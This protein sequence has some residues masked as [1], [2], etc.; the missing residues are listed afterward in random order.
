V[1][2][3][4]FTLL[5][6]IP[7]FGFNQD[8]DNTFGGDSLDMGYSLQQTIDDGYIITGSTESYGSGDADVYLIKTDANGTLFGLKP[9]EDL[10]KTMV[11]HYR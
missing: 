9:L 3:F 4:L 10:V 11:A 2:K 7:F 8:F 1:K 6:C 5:V